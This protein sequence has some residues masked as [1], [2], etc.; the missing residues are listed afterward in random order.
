MFVKDTLVQMRAI[1]TLSTNLSV[2]LNGMD[3]AGDGFGGVY[4]WI[5]D[6]I[7]ADNPLQ[8]IRPDDF[9]IARGGVWEKLI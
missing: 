8:T 9:S 3:A 7:G 4:R 1:P 6:G 2:Q 5:D